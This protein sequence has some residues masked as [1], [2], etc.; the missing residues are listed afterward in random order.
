M[1]LRSCGATLPAGTFVTAPL[2]ALGRA[3]AAYG[4]DAAEFRP[5]RWPAASRRAT[6][7]GESGGGGGGVAGST[8]GGGVAGSTGGG[9][10]STG[11]GAGSTGGGPPD[12]MPFSVGPRD[13]VG[14]ALAML[15]LQAVVATLVGRFRWAMP[16]GA[17]PLDAIA[18]YHITL[19]PEG[20]LPLLATPRTAADAD[21]AV[22]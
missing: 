13:C 3:A 11:G 1:T 15:E 20:G 21:V 17:P 19:F 8:G 22:A 5:E 16:P 4:A 6:A 10:G 14:Q 18:R 9:A 7:D 12:P 2:F